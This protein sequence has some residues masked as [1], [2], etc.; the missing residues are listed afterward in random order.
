MLQ[1]HLEQGRE[2]LPDLLVALEKV[3]IQVDPSY[4]PTA[5]DVKGQTHVCVAFVPPGALALLPSS[6]RAEFFGRPP[7]RKVD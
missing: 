5:L 7:G 6:W 4:P 3:G 1:V 2:L